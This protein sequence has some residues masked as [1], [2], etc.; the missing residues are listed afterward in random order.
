MPGATDVPLLP[1]FQWNPAD[2]ANG[3]EV[4]LSLNDTFTSPVASVTVANAVWVADVNLKTNTVY[5]WRVRAVSD[6]S[7]SEWGVG[8]FTTVGPPPPPP[9]APPAPVVVPPA[10][11][12]PAPVVIPPQ[13]APITPA[14]IWAIIIIGAV[15]VI[16]VIILIVRTRRI[17]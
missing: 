14:Y 2:W 10:V 11:N 15:L 7:Q 13:P 9:P 4:V 5:F 16:A 6:A 17:A 1:T 8:A 3:Y 12:M